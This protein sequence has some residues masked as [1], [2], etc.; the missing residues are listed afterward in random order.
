MTLTLIVEESASVGLSTCP[1]KGILSLP[2]LAE[3]TLSRNGTLLR[4]QEFPEVL[5][6]PSGKFNPVSREVEAE[7]DNA[8]W[9][10]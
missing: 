8:R 9:I 1:V 10:W 7:S 4:I 3:E 2:Y 5:V 6:L